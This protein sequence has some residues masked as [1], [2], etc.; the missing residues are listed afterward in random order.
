ML[1]AD[2]RPELYTNKNPNILAHNF[3]VSQ[4]NFVKGTYRRC[5]ISNISMENKIETM[6]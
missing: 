2:L 6:P 3:T 4:A 1:I 5:T